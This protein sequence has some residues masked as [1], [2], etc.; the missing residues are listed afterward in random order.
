MRAV[1]LAL[2][3]KAG[4]PGA[5]TAL[6]M[7][8][9]GFYDVLFKSGAFDLPRPFGTWV[10]ENVIFKIN[11]AEGHGM[12]AIE[13]ALEISNN[14]K[15][16]GLTSKDIANVRVRTT[17]SAMII[18]NK[19]GPLHNAADRDHCLKYM[20]AVVFRKGAMIDTQDYQDTSP[21]ALDPEV[22][23]FREKITLVEEVQFTRDYHDPNIRS[24]SNAV[25]VQLI[26]GISL[27]EVIIKYPQGH[28]SHAETP[29]LVQA[30]A[31]RN[32]SLKLPG[33]KVGGIVDTV[34]GPDFH[35]M[36]VSS[37]IDMFA[38]PCTEY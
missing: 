30:K 37:F 32:L 15:Q 38:I 29:D 11:T 1:H 20:L 6:T 13:A 34:Y 36:P 5:P 3:I 17:E 31:K 21:W 12:T 2:L 9:W 23:A 24:I 14:M 8:R 18:I 28:V 35:N 22:E 19:Q 25:Q 27:D 4:Q 33:E 26:D 7:P 10:I 16:R